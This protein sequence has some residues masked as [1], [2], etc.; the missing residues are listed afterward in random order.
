MLYVAD[1]FNAWI[2]ETQRSRWIRR[3]C[4]TAHQVV[5]VFYAY[6]SE[7]LLLLYQVKYGLTNDIMAQ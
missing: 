5:A 6:F 3:L 2:N 1:T 4:V 7:I